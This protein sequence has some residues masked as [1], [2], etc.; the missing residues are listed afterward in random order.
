LPS[1]VIVEHLNLLLHGLWSE[2]RGKNDIDTPRRLSVGVMDK[3]LA[4][5]R[6]RPVTLWPLQR[7]ADSKSAMKATRI[8]QD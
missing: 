6:I 7:T 4:V 3:L 8:L 1:K 2:W 5:F